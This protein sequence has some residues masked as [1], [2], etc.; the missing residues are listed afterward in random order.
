MENASGH[1]VSLP[2][3]YFQLHVVGMRWVR[4]TCWAGGCT[5]WLMAIRNNQGPVLLCQGRGSC[6]ICSDTARPCICLGDPRCY[7]GPTG[8]RISKSV[9]IGEGWR[10]GVVGGALMPYQCPF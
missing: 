9:V 6:T 5:G 3:I 8:S 7:P 1:R 4:E 10:Q 2:D